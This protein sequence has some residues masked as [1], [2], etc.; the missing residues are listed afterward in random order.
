MLGKKKKKIIYKNENKALSLGAYI[1]IIETNDGRVSMSDLNDS[2]FTKDMIKHHWGSLRVMDE[3]ARKKSPS[4]FYDISLEDLI[5]PKRKAEL[6][7]TVKNVKRFFISTAV[8]GC[9]ANDAFLKSIK[10]WCKRNNGALLVLVS[11]DPSHNLFKANSSYGYIDRKLENEHVIVEDTQ[12]NSNL[13]LSTIKLSAKHIDPITGL[14]R[15]GQ[16][17]GSFIYASPKQRMKCTPVGSAKLSHVL[18]T[19]GAMTNSNYNTSSYMAQR[20]AYIAEHDHI[21]GGII[22]EVVD[23]N[24]Y[25]YRQVQADANGSFVDLGM[26]YS[27]GRVKKMRPEA[28]I[29]GDVHV[30][31]TCPMVQKATDQLVK[32]LRPRCKVVHDMFNGMAISHHEEKNQIVR[33]MRSKNG[34]CDLDDELRMTATWLNHAAEDVDE[35]IIVKSNH[36]EF[37]ERYLSE[38]RYVKDPQN[39]RLSLDLA[40]AFMDGKDPLKTGIAR[41]NIP[42]KGKIRWLSRD[43]DFKIANIQLGAHGDKGSSGTRGNIRSTEA[44]Y[45]NSVTGHSHTPE[46][47]RGAFVVGT[48]TPLRLIYT[49]GPSSWMNTHC[50]LYPNGSRQ[51][52]NIINGEYRLRD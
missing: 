47:L 50:L 48:S 2:G 33:A 37:L 21:L 46:I 17:E 19:T 30:G 3:A 20:T 8:T 41:Y 18:M 39:H 45:G 52:I 28:I 11:S 23:D 14:S 42:N 15:I 6:R 10:G 38:G 27:G 9:Q 12:I 25:H 49:K 29:M 34:Q 22:V 4:S 31:E 35:V 24:V 44:A 51:L 26:C 32:E 43:E 1:S 13:F 36:D 5:V 7:S 40:A 16:R